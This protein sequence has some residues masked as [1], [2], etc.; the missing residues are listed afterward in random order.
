[1]SLNAHSEVVVALLRSDVDH[2]TVVRVARTAHQWSQSELGKRCGYSASQVSRWETGRLPLRDVDLLRVLADVLDLP[3]AAFGLGDTTG[4][5]SQPASAVGHRLGRTTNPA[6]ANPTAEEDELVRRRSFLQLAAVTGSTLALPAATPGG[7]APD[8]AD[9]LARR[10][11]DVLLGPATGSPAPVGVLTEALRIARHEFATCR[12]LPLASRLPALIHAAEATAAEHADPTVHRVLAASYN[13]V[14]RALGKL[15]V[16]GLQWLSADRA[17][18]AA[19]AAEDPLTLAEA[20]RLV[21]TV[22]RRAGHHDRAQTLTLAA[23]EH[24]DV[25]SARPA[26]RHLAMYATLHLSAAYAAA[27]AGDR[28]RASDLMSEAETSVNRLVDD[29]DRHRALAANLVS[30]HVSAACVLGDAGTALAHATS[31]PLAAIPTTER[32]ARLLVD[33]AQA[34]A[35]WDKPGQAYRTLLLAERTAPGEVHTRSAARRL[36]TDLIASPKQASMPG[37]AALAHRVHATTARPA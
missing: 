30:H 4:R 14:T 1:M 13:L 34:W 17:L 29:P 24:L 32:R 35:Q 12:Y 11:G 28:A 15:D 3:P 10:L 16:S 9:A 31:L 22:A 6:V 37:L 27:G 21:A 23:A 2:G 18:L 19:R 20:Q 8:P 26:P 33:T 36:V 25:R 7:S 5:A